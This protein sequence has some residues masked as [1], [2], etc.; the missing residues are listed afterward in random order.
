MKLFT[1]VTGEYT[2]YSEYH[3]CVVCNSAGKY[4]INDLFNYSDNAYGRVGY[5]LVIKVK[6][7][8]QKL[9]RHILRTESSQLIFQV[10]CDI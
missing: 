4:V 1:Y 8:L 10:L 3:V 6:I 5:N 9:L 2:G 7:Q